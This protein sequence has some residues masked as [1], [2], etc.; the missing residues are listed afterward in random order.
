MCMSGRGDGY[1]YISCRLLILSPLN[2]PREALKS[3]RDSVTKLSCILYTRK[4]P[5]FICLPTKGPK[6]TELI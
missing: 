3:Y 4:P 5:P 1:H 2:Y 6:G